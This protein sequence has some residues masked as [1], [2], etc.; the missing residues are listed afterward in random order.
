MKR[1]TRQIAERSAETRSAEQRACSK[2][3]HLCFQRNV[4]IKSNVKANVYNVNSR[5]RPP[6][7]IVSD[8]NTMHP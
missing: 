8:T 3:R 6:V 4:F 7:A 5:R 1:K 2:A